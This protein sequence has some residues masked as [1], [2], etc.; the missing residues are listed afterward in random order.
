MSR[1]THP[2][3]ERLLTLL[4]EYLATY[5]DMRVGQAI[6]AA[7]PL[8]QREAVDR[9]YYAEDGELA[10]KLEQLLGRKERQ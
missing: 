6:S 4:E 10:D 3:R 7:I 1:L 9:L 2:D 8:G 5:P